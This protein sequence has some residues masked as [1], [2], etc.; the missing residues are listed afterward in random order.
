MPVPKGAGC[1]DGTHYIVIIGDQ[2]TTWNFC[3]RSNAE[4]YAKA[5][6]KKYHLPGRISIRKITKN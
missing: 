1:G 5:E 6:K 3:K 4:A 2:D